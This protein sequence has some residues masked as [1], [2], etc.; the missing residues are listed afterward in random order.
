MWDGN[1]R[2]QSTRE[3]CGQ[4]IAMTNDI[5]EIKTI[6]KNIE[7]STTQGVTFKTAMVGSMIGIV[8]TILI[9]L[10][11]F[12]FLYGKLVNQVIVNTER[13]EKLENPHVSQILPKM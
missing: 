10:S 1:E 11:I 5:V 13:L 12:S 6:L 4:H 9:Q 7:K 8:L 3:F 2:R